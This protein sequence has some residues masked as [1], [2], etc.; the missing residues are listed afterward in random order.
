MI[1]LALCFAIGF[2]VGCYTA[3]AMRGRSRWLSLV[4]A[5]VITAGSVLAIEAVTGWR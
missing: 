5:I 1:T 2:P 4:L 3:Y